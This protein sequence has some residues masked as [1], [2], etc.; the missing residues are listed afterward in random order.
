MSSTSLHHPGGDR[1]PPACW[2]HHDQ[3]RQPV[4][5]VRGLMQM[6]AASHRL[7]CA[8]SSLSCAQ[9][10]M[11]RSC[12]GKLGLPH[13]FGETDASDMHYKPTSLV[14]GPYTGEG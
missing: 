9:E 11:I 8:K 6:T 4:T 10:M 13:T 2:A 5:N 14:Y 3:P 7:V 12:L 1:A